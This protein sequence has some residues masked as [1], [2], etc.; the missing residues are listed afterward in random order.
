M[1]IYEVSKDEIKIEFI[2]LS[3]LDGI[4]LKI[5]SLVKDWFMRMTQRDL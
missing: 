3:I 1:E 5:L 2:W 4:K